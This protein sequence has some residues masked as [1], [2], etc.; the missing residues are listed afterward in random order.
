MERMAGLV[1]G[2]HFT[3]AKMSCAFDYACHLLHRAA[4]LALI[5]VS[6]EGGRWLRPAQAGRCRQSHPEPPRQ[7]RSRNPTAG[8][9]MGRRES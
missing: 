9:E 6:A 1:S 3:D 8:S 5:T 2:V 7:R 4:G